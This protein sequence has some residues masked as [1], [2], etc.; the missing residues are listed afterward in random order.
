MLIP[1]AMVAI[2]ATTG[3]FSFSTTGRARIDL[4]VSEASCTTDA[5]IYEAHVA[6]KEAVLQSGAKVQM[7]RRRRRQ[8]CLKPMRNAPQ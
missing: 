3:R 6:P 4:K 2:L 1:L 5:S 7:R 8:L